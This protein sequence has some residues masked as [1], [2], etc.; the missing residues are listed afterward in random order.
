MRPA[1][2]KGNNKV[3]KARRAWVPFVVGATVLAGSAAPA[4]ASSTKSTSSTPLN[5]AVVAGFTGSQA[6][7][8]DMWIAGLRVAASQINAQGGILGHPVKLHTYDF[9]SEPTLSLAMMRKALQIHPYVVMGTILSGATLINYPILQN[10]GV[11]QFTGSTDPAIE[12]KDPASLFDMEP[13]STLE[14]D[15]FVKWAVQEAHVKR[16]DIVYANDSFGT[17][18]LQSFA[19]V[20]KKYGAD[21]VSEIST[22]VGQT[23][24]SGVVAK[25][26]QDKPDAVFM[27]M[28]ETETGKFLTQSH[29]A[30]LTSKIKF[31]GASSALSPA[32][33]KIAGSASNGLEGFVPFSEAAPGQRA[34]AA[35]YSRSHGGNLPDHNFYKAYVALWAVDYATTAVGTLDQKAMVKWLHNRTL[36]VSKYPHLI[37]DTYWSSNGNLDI[38]GYIVKAENGKQVLQARTPAPLPAQLAACGPAPKA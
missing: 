1:K 19:P 4:G 31:L 10:A 15:M 20:F 23:D 35:I 33:L 8:A 28:H 30:G 2:Q 18:G 12:A 6:P 24:F 27:Y 11:P 17:A 22:S 32:A 7:S 38:Y 14:A 21:V 3:V 26:E 16:L 34:L 9:Q 36:C 25:V 5:I 29:E 13:N 37:G